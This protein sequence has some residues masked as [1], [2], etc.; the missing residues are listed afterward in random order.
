MLT[1][2]RVTAE[3]D[4]ID[5]KRR[6]TYQHF[7]SKEK[8]GLDKR[9]AELGI[10]TVRYLTAKSGEERTGLSPS[11]L[12]AWKEKYLRELKQRR[13]DEDPSINE[14]PSKKEGGYYWI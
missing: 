3:D 4:E 7:T 14:L 10:S 8:L 11:T 9:A 5:D 12:F 1:A 13:S 6:G 2:S